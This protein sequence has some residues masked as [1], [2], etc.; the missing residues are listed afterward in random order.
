M[1]FDGA[2]TAS[3]QDGPSCLEPLEY[4]EDLRGRDEVDMITQNKVH[5]LVEEA[6][7]LCGLE[8]ERLAQMKFRRA[9]QLLEA[10]IRPQ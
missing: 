9:V 2:G 6:R 10:A 4:I 1:I 5:N 7:Q 3:A 8:E